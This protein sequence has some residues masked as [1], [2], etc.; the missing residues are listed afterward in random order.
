MIE[1]VGE[2]SVESEGLASDERQRSNSSYTTRELLVVYRE[3][4]TSRTRTHVV[5]PA[6]IR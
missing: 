2:D 3:G 5:L 6:E 1:G 4:R